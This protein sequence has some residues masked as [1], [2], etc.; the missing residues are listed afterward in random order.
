MQPFQ[1]LLENDWQQGERNGRELFRQLQAQGYPGSYRTIARFLQRLQQPTQIPHQSRNI[2]KPRRRFRKRS[3]PTPRQAAFLVLK[4]PDKLSHKQQQ[5]LSQLRQQPTFSLPLQLAQDFINIVRQRQGERFDS[6]L[7][8]VDGSLSKPL[9]AFANSLKGDYDAVFTALSSHFSNGPTEGH[10]NKLK[11]IKRQM[12]GRAPP[13][14][15]SRR[16]LL[17][18]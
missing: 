16:F 17:A 15:L 14:L 6:W 8:Q 4:Q 3:K 2:S 18:H 13:Q 11:F 9:I 5:Q 1:A 10:I 7:H 12:F